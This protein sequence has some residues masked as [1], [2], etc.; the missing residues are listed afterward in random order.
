[1]KSISLFFVEMQCIQD[2]KFFKLFNKKQLMIFPE[3]SEFL[4]KW[5]QSQK[6]DLP[7]RNTSNAYY[8]WLSEIILQQTRVVQGLPYYLKFIDKYPTI[9]DLANAPESEVLKLW[10]GLGYYSRAR[11]L[12]QT[13]KIVSQKFNNIF[14]KTYAEI[15]QLKGIG[16]YTASAISS[17]C[18]NEAVA[19]V[20][21]NVFRVLSRIFNI[22]I[23]I[24]TS[25]GMKYFKNLA[26][27]LLDKNRAGLHNQAIMEFGAIHCKPQLP[28]C[29]TCIFS[30]KCLALSLKKVNELPVKLKKTIIKNRYF[31]YLL[32]IDNLQNTLFEQRKGKDIWNGLYQF[33]LIESNQPIQQEEIIAQIQQKY[34]KIISVE[35][36]SEKTHKLSH[37]H[38]FPTFWVIHT[39]NLLENSIP[40]HEI[41]RFPMP[42][43]IANFLKKLQI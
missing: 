37:Q 26:T 15:K 36:F 17:I 33:P 29:S 41:H 4:I 5:Y 20:D 25:E 35:K 38:I 27:E 1:M 6:R 39:D 12:H 10:Q 34:P 9:N 2:N 18:Y 30:E 42:I 23:P 40:L 31:N 43:L 13:A 28:N 22:D 19:V 8:V 11:N 16:D 24:N 21:G 3:F 7:W 32:M 14:P